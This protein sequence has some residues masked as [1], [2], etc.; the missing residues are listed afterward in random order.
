[1][2][3]DPDAMLDPYV[4]DPAM[5]A[6]AQSVAFFE[7]R[8][9]LR[10]TF[11]DPLDLL[12]KVEQLHTVPTWVVQGTEDQVRGPC[13]LLPPRLTHNAFAQG[14]PNGVCQAVSHRVR[15][16]KCAMLCAFRRRRPQVYFKE[17]RTGA[18][19]KQKA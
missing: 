19:R 16:S 12:A 13:S 15:A 9:F 2:E 5:F 7:T 6:E 3:E 14:V 11:E 18:Q 10:G 8:L 1:M 4:I 17:H